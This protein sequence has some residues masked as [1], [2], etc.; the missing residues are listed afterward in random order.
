MLNEKELNAILQRMDKDDI[1]VLVDEIEKIKSIGWI[2][3]TIAYMAFISLITLM[4]SLAFGIIS[5]VFKSWS[6]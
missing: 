2:G 4:F 3:K 1:P 6:S 5:V